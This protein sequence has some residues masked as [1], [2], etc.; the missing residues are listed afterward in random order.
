MQIK[1]TD[2]SIHQVTQAQIQ[3][4]YH[5]LNHDTKHEDAQEDNIWL[6]K[7]VQK[8]HDA[9]MQ[10]HH[11]AADNIMRIAQM[12]HAP[13]TCDDVRDA[14]IEVLM[15]GPAWDQA[16]MIFQVSKWISTKEDHCMLKKALEVL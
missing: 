14:L 10:K 16:E 12:D 6:S 11:E 3:R 13:Q 8:V 1:L 15:Y 9:T 5:M 7:I 2:G 4:V